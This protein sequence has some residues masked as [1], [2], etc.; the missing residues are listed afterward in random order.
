MKDEF[1]RSGVVTNIVD[2]DRFDATV[3]L[4]YNMHTRQRFRLHDIDCP[5]SYRPRNEAERI[6]GNAAK[7][8]VTSK[9]LNQRVTIKSYYFGIYNRMSCDV[10]Y[11]EA[12]ETKSLVEELKKN[13]Y[14]KRQSYES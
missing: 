2:G 12:G 3:D 5:E 1:I 11:E 6:H 4:G 13:G 7:T 10:F 14:T 8:F 9:I